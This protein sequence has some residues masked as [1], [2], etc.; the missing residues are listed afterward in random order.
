VDAHGRLLPLTAE[1]R[2]GR[3]EAAVRALAELRDLPH[4]DPRDTLEGLMRALDENRAH[5]RRLFEGVI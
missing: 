5:D 1:E 2:T 3:T 4:D